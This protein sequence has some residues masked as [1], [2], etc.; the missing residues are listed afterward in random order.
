MGLFGALGCF[1]DC[2]YDPGQV[3]FCLEQD[4]LIPQ[5]LFPQLFLLLW[6]SQFVSEIVYVSLCFCLSNRCLYAFLSLLM[7]LSLSLSFTLYFVSSS[8]WPLSL[9]LSFSLSLS[10]PP[11]RLQWEGLI[12]EREEGRGRE[13]NMDR[14]PL[15]LSLQ[16]GLCPDKESTGNLLVH[17]TTLQPTEPPKPV[18]HTCILN[19][20]KYFAFL[21]KASCILLFISH[22]SLCHY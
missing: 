12:L 13:R 9:S 19:V 4:F 16:P 20:I 1:P 11:V 18:Q 17:G 8:L 10:P 14:L 15:V 7:S 3:P 21:N 22:V 5:G 6:F 2:L